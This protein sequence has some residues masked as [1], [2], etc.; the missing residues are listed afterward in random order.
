[1]KILITGAAGFIGKNLTVALEAIRDGKDKTHPA[2]SVERL[3]LADRDTTS[4]ELARACADCDFVFHLAGVNRPEHEAE[5]TEGN[6]TFT[7][8]L[9]TALRDR[10]NAC[11]IVFAS[12]VQAAN[13]TP[14]GRSK[15]AAETLL[16]AYAK[17]CGAR[18]LVYRL[19]NVFGKWCR[20]YYNSVV[21]TFCH[22]IARDLP[23]KIHDRASVLELAY[24]DDVVEAFCGA[25]C[26]EELCE[27]DYCKI[28]T[29][30]STTVGEIADLLYG[31]RESRKTLQLPDMPSGSLQKKLY[32]TYLSYLPVDAFSYPLHAHADARGAFAEF[33]RTQG[34]GQISLNIIKPGA[35]KGNHWHHT[36]NEKFLTVSGSGVIRL[37]KVGEKTVY[38]YPVSGAQLSVVDIP[39]GYTHNI[40]NC[41]DADLVTV[42]WC[43]ECFDSEKP[44][45]FYL[46]V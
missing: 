7:E 11:P 2:L 32:S 34:C 8:T 5:F 24:I 31:F 44:D 15:R 25:L 28:P 37:R 4:Q 3:Y 27:G 17:A 35:V 10:H 36:K 22:N 20:P 21:A 42:I 6:V 46:E 13:D 45:T 9:L 1:M 14:Y 18:V 40:E 26:G 16:S 33:L 30:H 19:P 41:G 39:V 29:V 23:I 12:S 43:N 38:T